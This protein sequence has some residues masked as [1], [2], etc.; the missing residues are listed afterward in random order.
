MRSL[1]GRQTFGFSLPTSHSSNRTLLVCRLS[2]ESAETTRAFMSGLV[3][4]LRVV[5]DALTCEAAR[6]ETDQPMNARLSSMVSAITVTNTASSFMAARGASSP[7][8]LLLGVWGFMCNL[9]TYLFAMVG[10][11]LQCVPPMFMGGFPA[12][13]VDSG[14]TQLQPRAAH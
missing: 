5:R 1:H 3:A 2:P 12:D 10:S 7:S 6:A 13:R 8:R 4:L 9:F 11:L 14:G